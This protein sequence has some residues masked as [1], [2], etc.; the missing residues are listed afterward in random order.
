MQGSIPKNWFAWIDN[1]AMRTGKVARE[2]HL[3]AYPICLRK[4][5]AVKGQ[6]QDAQFREITYIEIMQLHLPTTFTYPVEFYDNLP[7]LRGELDGEPGLFLFDSGAQDITLN[8]KYLD[9]DKLAEGSKVHGF[10]G[11]VRTF[12]KPIAELAFGEWRFQNREAI[13]SDLSHTE[14]EFGTQMHGLIG[15]RQLIHFDWMIDYKKG[16]LHL[17]ERFDRSGVK[18]AG[19]VS[20]RY[21][22]HLPMIEIHVNGHPFNMLLDTG[23][24]MF[25]L[26]IDH[27]DLV[28][29]QVTDLVEE[30][31]ASASPVKI[32]VETGKLAGFEIAGLAFGES[33]IKLSDLGMIKKH[34]KGVDGIVGYPILSQYRTV[35]NWSNSTLLFLED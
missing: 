12:Y 8:T 32:P 5:Q 11:K 25:L 34:F 10:T 18:L 6:M 17:W 13:A 4:D 28:I 24:S 27:K 20:C 21:R 16:I 14:E 7:F 33:E 15:F 26:D 35:I 3:S 1:T 2:G 29:D 31:M 19:K 9:L 23:A 30:E 22:R